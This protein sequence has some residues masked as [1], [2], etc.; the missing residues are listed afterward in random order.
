GFLRYHWC[1]STLAFGFEIVDVGDNRIDVGVAEHLTEG[2]HCALLTVLDAVAD[3]LVTALCIHQLRT[4]PGGAAPIAVA[5]AAIGGEQY[6]DVEPRL[7]R[8]PSCR[9]RRS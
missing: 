6:P 2:W 9:K 1:Q 8:R 5:E 3:E 7:R 4:F